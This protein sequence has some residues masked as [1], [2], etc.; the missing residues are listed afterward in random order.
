VKTK[1]TF[2]DESTTVIDASEAD[3]AVFKVLLKNQSKIKVVFTGEDYFKYV[4]Y[5]TII[6]IDQHK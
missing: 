5:V 6:G 3:T 4:K 1:L 2:D